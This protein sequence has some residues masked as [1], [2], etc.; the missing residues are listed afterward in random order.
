MASPADRQVEA[1]ETIRRLAEGLHE[2]HRE[3]AIERG[4]RPTRPPWALEPTHARVDWLRAV[5]RALATDLIRPGA[6]PDTGPDP[7]PNQL[8]IDD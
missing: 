6:R 1:T 7:M 2:F 8:S 5:S 4:V 3:V